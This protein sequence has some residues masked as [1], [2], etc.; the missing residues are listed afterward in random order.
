M[1][2]VG[3]QGEAALEGGVCFLPPPQQ[4]QG[5]TQLEVGFLQLWVQAHGLFQQRQRLLCLVLLHQQR[6]QVLV[7]FGERGRQLNDP[8]EN[9][10]RL[11][12]AAQVAQRGA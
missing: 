10:F 12:K 7:G 6:A 2:R 8:A 1:R 11:V 5:F 9:F 4:G 3:R